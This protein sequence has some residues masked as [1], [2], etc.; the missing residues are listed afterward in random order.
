MS[1]NHRGIFFGS[2][3]RQLYRDNIFS[4]H[5]C[6]FPLHPIQPLPMH[7][8][9]IVYIEMFSLH[10]YFSRL[11]LWA[12]FSLSFTLKQVN[13][14]S[15]NCDGINK[16]STC[17]QVHGK[18]FSTVG[19]RSKVKFYHVTWSCNMIHRFWLSP[20]KLCWIL[21]QYKGKTELHRV[22]DKKGPL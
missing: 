6:K 1:K 7:P 3:C 5:P 9:I 12:K 11:S 22:P 10:I 4:P 14:D 21:L 16:N 18:H 15:R 20:L 2:H 19:S 8:I 17:L 13:A